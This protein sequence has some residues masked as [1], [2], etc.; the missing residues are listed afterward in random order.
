MK[1]I[2]SV[3]DFIDIYQKLIHKGPRFFLKKF[4]ISS[5]SRVINAWDANENPPIHWWSIPK[6]NERWNKIITG[7][8]NI[9]FPDYVIAKYLKNERN[10][11][12]ISPGCGTG[13]IE[14]KFA[15]HNCFSEVEGFD[16]S[17]SRIHL[18]DENAKR[19][20]LKNLFYFVENVHKYDFG[21]N[22]YDI[23]LFNSSLHHFNNLKIILEKVYNSIKLD[24]L[25]I[26]NEYTGPN[27]FQW[28][29][30]QF[31]KANQYLNKIPT[32]YRKFWQSNNI[33]K[34][35]YRPGILR[36]I[37][38]D[39]SESS[40]SE[41]I[42][43]QIK[44]RFKKIEEKPYGGNLLHLIFKDI[45]HNFIEDTGDTNKILNFLFQAEDDFLEKNKSDFIFGIYTK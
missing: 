35:I 33:K 39:P 5:T 32:Q 4:H 34:K 7:D 23:I 17:P 10:L 20:K 14:I 8:S 18:A 13:H 31:K 1:T 9:E 2:I 24:G 44:M 21:F 37:L 16:L 27:R 26:I 40:H 11:K 15:K 36:M 12:L 19:L 41:E 3:G 6:I 29:D 30:E 22:K 45:S 25:L 28:T 38:S 42:L 43:P